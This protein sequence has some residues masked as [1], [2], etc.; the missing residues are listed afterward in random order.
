MFSLSVVS[1][2]VRAKS[3]PLALNS[4]PPIII[5][6]LRGSDYMKGNLL[7]LGMIFLMVLLISGCAGYYG[8]YGYPYDN[9]YSYGNDYPY[10]SN[11]DHEGRH[12]E[13]HEGGEFHHGGGDH[14]GGGGESHGGKG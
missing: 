1:F 6:R 4:R 12:H 13:H 14:H 8:D 11:G 10:F 5:L 9:G 3:V 7:F 2:S